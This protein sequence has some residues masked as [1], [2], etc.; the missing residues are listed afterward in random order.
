MTLILVTNFYEKSKIVSSITSYNIKCNVQKIIIQSVKFFLKKN[1]FRKTK[2]SE[3]ENN[4][5]LFSYTLM[6][7]ILF[8][9]SKILL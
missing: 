5:H 6:I 7:V 1:K 8:K 3:Y 4:A 9:F 2:K